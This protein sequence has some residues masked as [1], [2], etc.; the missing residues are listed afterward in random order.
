MVQEEQVAL[1][2]P[3]DYEQDEHYIQSANVNHQY[4]NNDHHAT[5]N[6]HC[7]ATNRLIAG[8]Q[9]VTTSFITIRDH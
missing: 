6:H 2:E 8:C 9:T 5:A 4:H 7:F 1:K 3:K